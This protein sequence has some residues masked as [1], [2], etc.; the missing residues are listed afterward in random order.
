MSILSK[1]IWAFISLGV[2]TIWG[3]TLTGIVMKIFARVQG[4][5]GPPV[6]QPFIDIFKNNAKRTAVSHGVMFYLGPVFRIAGGIGTYMFIPV[7]FGSLYFS[8]F[9]VSGDV[10][11]VMYFIFFGQL[12]MALGAGEGGHP[13]SAIAVARG[14]AQMT[15]F[16]VPFALSVISLA[17]QYGTLNI[18]DIV[19]AQQG[20]FLHWTMFTNPLAVIAAMIAMLGMN[21]YN[22][23]S[24]VIAPQEIPIG[25]PT[26]YQASFLGLLA[27]N[28]GIFNGAK[29]VLFMNLYFGGATNLP[30]MVVKT[31]CIYMF[32][33]FVGAAF[34]R[35][36]AEDSI[37]FFLKYPTLIGIAAV[38][39]WTI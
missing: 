15:A 5:L 19:A 26:E 32:S 38:L 25:P 21:M 4:R 23:F 3:L 27:T 7:L 30:M 18:T 14:L 13:Y 17:V 22:P 39:I 37:R 34:P 16:E 2:V 36:R 33:V 35:F 6:W 9:S 31:F 8:N 28:R 24:L 12:G 29:L 1:I 20:G 11:L 10:L